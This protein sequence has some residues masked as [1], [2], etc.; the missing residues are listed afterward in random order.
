MDYI[1][2]KGRSDER[3]AWLWN[4]SIAEVRTA[5]G[6][7]TYEVD[8]PHAITY[9]YEWKANGVSGTVTLEFG[10]LDDPPRCQAVSVHWN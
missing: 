1:N 2:G 5:L 6:K 3:L 10:K 9:R 4:R 8:R 7:P